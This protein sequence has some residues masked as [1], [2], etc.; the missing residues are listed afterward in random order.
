[1]HHGPYVGSY[2]GC[3]D[4]D[5]EETFLAWCGQDYNLNSLARWTRIEWHRNPG[6]LHVF[7]LSKTPLRNMRYKG[8]E[9]YN[10]KPNLICVYGIHKDGN[11]IEP[12]GTKKIAVVDDAKLLDIK[13]RIKLVI[14]NHIYDGHN[15]NTAAHQRIEELEKSETVVGNGHVHNAMARMM[16]SFFFRYKGEWAYMSD[17]Q[18]FQQAIDWERQKALQVNR[19]AYIDTNPSKVNRLWE[20]VKRKFGPKRQK[21]REEL[22]IPM[23]VNYC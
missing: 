22:G 18:R 13:N 12:Y 2:L 6:K 7:F 3:I 20:D 10:E 1:L 19:P 4:F 17:E 16:T 8:I 5:N 23:P 11:R 9:V 21:E 14:P 15:D